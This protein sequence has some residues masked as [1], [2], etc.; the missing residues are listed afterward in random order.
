MDNRFEAPNLGIQHTLPVRRERE[1]PTPL[2]VFIGGRS[3]VR[4]HNKI[5]LLEFPK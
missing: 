2:V 1:V 4:L 5:G 3:V